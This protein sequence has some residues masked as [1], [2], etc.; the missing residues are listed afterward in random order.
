MSRALVAALRQTGAALAAHRRLILG[1]IFTRRPSP[2]LQRC[3]ARSGYGF[4]AAQKAVLLY[5]RVF[6]SVSR[7]SSSS[8]SSGARIA[9][10]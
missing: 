1:A 3:E 4:F 2:A 10:A 7:K 9:L 8:V 5:G 6:T